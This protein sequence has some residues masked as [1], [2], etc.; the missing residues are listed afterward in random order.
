MQNLENDMDDLFQRAA[1]NYS[2]KNESGDWGSVSKKLAARADDDVAPIPLNTKRSKKLALFF[3]MLLFMF[4]AGFFYYSFKKEFNHAN[5]SAGLAK[6]GNK[7]YTFPGNITGSN[8]DVDSRRAGIISSKEKLN[9]KKNTASNSNHLLTA[10]KPANGGSFSE[11][12]VKSSAGDVYRDGVKNEENDKTNFAPSYSKDANAKTGN[13]TAGNL[14]GKNDEI[15]LPLKKENEKLSDQ[16]VESSRNMIVQSARKSAV[17]KKQKGFYIG[18]ITGL[19][20]SKV[21]S[22]SFNNSGFET[23][24][25]FGYRIGHTLSLETGFLWNKKYYSSDGRHFSMNKIRSSMPS[26]MVINNLESQSSLVEIPIKLKVDFKHKSNSGLFVTGGVSSYIMTMEKNTYN[27]T[28]N[29][30]QEKVSGVYGKNNYGFLT[31]ANLSLGYQRYLSK[32]IDLRI[33][34]FLKIPLQGIGVGNLPVTS[35]GIQIAITHH[36]N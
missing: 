31:V 5:G 17:I 36:L 26:G 35:A 30:N 18:I 8:Q 34:P 25:L 1:E 21:A 15:T 32:V 12:N 19:D 7:T 4:I 13:V 6:P 33:E 29:G 16:N 23:G 20:F 27:A 2:L 14:N 9:S 11:D 3:T 22:S 24:L 10:I 28:L